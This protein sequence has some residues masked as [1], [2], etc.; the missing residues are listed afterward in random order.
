MGRRPESLHRRDRFLFTANFAPLERGDYLLGQ[1]AGLALLFA[2]E[3]AHSR[4]GKAATRGLYAL[5]IAHNPSHDHLTIAKI[6]VLIVQALDGSAGLTAGTA[7]V[8]G[9]IGHA[10]HELGIVVAGHIAVDVGLA[11]VI[12]LADPSH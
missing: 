11:G 10:L 7:S 5:S 1:T 3:G 4:V 2:G 9:A 6:V 8:A 12:G